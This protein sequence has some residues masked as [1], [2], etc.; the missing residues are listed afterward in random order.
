MPFELDPDPQ[1]LG[2]TAPYLG[3]WF[4]NN[5]VQLPAPQAGD[6]LGLSVDLQGD[7]WRP[8]ATGFLSL[9]IGDPAKPPA[10]LNLLRD[11]KGNHPFAADQ[12]IAL[13]TLLPEVQARLRDLFRQIP[14][15]V[16]GTQQTP[17]PN[18]SRLTVRSFAL[19]LPSLTIDELYALIP[20]PANFSLKSEKAA[21]LGLDLEANTFPK[22][23]PTPMTQLLRPGAFPLAGGVVSVE[24]DIILTGL[25][26]G[27]TLWAFDA[28]GRAIDPGA[29]AAWFSY[30][31]QQSTFNGSPNAL[32]FGDTTDWPTDANNN[33][34]VAQVASGRVINL[35][36]AHE[37]PLAAPFLG[38]SGRL[39]MDGS[40]VTNTVVLAGTSAS[41]FTFTAPPAPGSVPYNPAVDNAPEKRMALLPDGTYGSTLTLWPNGQPV[42]T[43]L[44]RDFARVA[45]VDIE[46][47]LTGLERGP[48]PNVPTDPDE[49]RKADQNRPSTRTK[50]AAC[51]VPDAEDVLLDTAELA[52]ERMIRGLIDGTS[53]RLVVGVADGQGG[54]LSSPLAA[55][56]AGVPSKLPGVL[57][58]T[59]NADPE[60]GTF[61][62]RPLTGCQA[63][64]TN[65]GQQVLLEVKLSPEVA[66]AWVRA[67]PLGFDIDRA[68]HFRMDGGGG[69]IAADGT[70]RLVMELA[71]KVTVG[72]DPSA[73][74]SFDLM[75]IGRDTGGVLRRRT[76]GDCRYHRPDP[77]PGNLVETID[78]TMTWFVCETG[79]TGT[80]VP[81]EKV[82]PGGTLLIKKTD[83]TFTLAARS[84]IP[85][86]ALVSDT[87]V[88][89]LGTGDIISL[90][91]PTFKATPDRHDDR[92]RLLPSDT[93]GGS[94]PGGLVAPNVTGVIVDRT[95]RF[96]RTGLRPSMPYPTQDRFEVI[97]TWVQ[98]SDSH[99]IVGGASLLS[100]SHELL[101]HDAGH[102]GSAAGVETHGTGVRLQGPAAQLA[103]EYMIDRT[104]G[105]GVPVPQTLQQAMGDIWVRSEPALA[106]E[107]ARPAPPVKQATSPGRWAAV[108]KTNAVGME[109]LPGIAALAYDPPGTLELYPLSVAAD[110]VETWLNSFNIPNVSNLG[111]Q[112]KNMIEPIADQVLRSLD[113]RI[114]ATAKGVREVVFSL[115]DAFKRAQDFIYIETPA[116]GD[117]GHGPDDDRMMLFDFLKQ[118]LTA[119][120]GLHLVVA[121]A[122]QMPLGLPK[123]MIAVRDDELVA[124]LDPLK[125]DDALKDRVAYFAVGAGAGRSLRLASTTV[126]VDDVFALTGTTHLWRRGLTFDSSLAAAVFDERLVD[127][128][129][130]EVRNFR[131]KLLAGRLGI[132]E[133]LVPEEPGELVRAIKDFDRTGSFRL[134]SHAVQTP[135]KLSADPNVAY[136]TDDDRAVWNVDGSIADVSFAN[137]VQFFL[138]AT[139]ST[140]PD[141]TVNDPLGP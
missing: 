89:A 139:A 15:L 2:I 25:P 104:A 26:A 84:K 116:I 10:P 8:P 49:R 101:P 80:N 77:V 119:K 86:T 135:D 123:S 129:P 73:M 76:Y 82:P 53:S 74:P 14:P 35:V 126:I 61:K 64:T 27:A 3:R 37:A 93:N 19:A 106:L 67:W 69:L 66:G 55:T 110:R 59:T 50:V 18:P 28:R 22:N 113:R 118:Q 83:G 96:G 39:Q 7:D 81:S 9:F 134:A 32:A 30:L 58:E 115:K 141:G 108:L 121:I 131:R 112:I 125:K 120:P 87:L 33:L 79:E 45:A 20:N 46:R 48:S 65:S 54:R 105:L 42:A 16:G 100:R 31:V 12:V 11:A 47:H 57:V 21:Y 99:A 60:L 109:G 68:E 133:S 102:P 122:A 85:T 90:T 94:L 70:A 138:R 130:R 6:T 92:G 13:F 72:I 103:Y 23:G 34:L 24:G 128:R 63:P 4:T 124:L 136:P 51:T 117:R 97:A 137:V 75:I 1:T 52:A 127:G 71:D 140:S 78:A 38:S 17:L 107:A 29:V 111:T 41:A 44:E 91:Q 98:D 36:D 56:I 95:S 5:Q 62:I 132:A 114:N 40:N 88:R 43:G